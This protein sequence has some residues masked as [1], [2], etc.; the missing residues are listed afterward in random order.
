MSLGCMDF[1][2]VSCLLSHVGLLLVYGLVRLVM[3]YVWLWVSTLS[4]YKDIFLL[5]C[6]D[7]IIGDG[8]C[9]YIYLLCDIH[10]ICITDIYV[11]PLHTHNNM[12]I[13]FSLHFHL[14][15]AYVAF[16][17]KLLIEMDTFRRA[18]PIHGLKYRFIYVILSFIRVVINHKRGECKCVNPV[19]GFWWIYDDAYK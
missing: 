13:N 18:C 4:I 12:C 19:C 11:T 9:L 14:N 1:G 3:N 2:L 6:L 16:Y 17:A 8:V 5:I 10:V 15:C 7:D